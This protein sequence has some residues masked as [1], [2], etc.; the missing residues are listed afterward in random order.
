MAYQQSHTERGLCQ[1]YNIGLMKY[2]DALNL[3][4]RLQKARIRGELYDD[5]V[6]IVEHYPVLTVGKSGR[7]HD[8]LVSQEVLAE[9][10][11]SVIHTE[12]GGGVTFH[13]PGQLVVYPIFDLK[14]MEKSLYQYV[15]DLEEVVIRVLA[16]FSILGRRVEKYPGVWVGDQKICAIGIHILNGVT[17]HGFALNVNNE[18]KYFSYIHPC[19]IQDRGVTSISKVLQQELTIND[20]LPFLVWHF[21]QVFNFKKM[22]WNTISH[23][24]KYT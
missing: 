5:L 12:R 7:K 9:K 14:R 6:L 4:Q 3:Q 15:R 2:E 18:L 8:I 19:G 20:V 22:N 24:S 17:S 16:D 11:I 1:I 23:L 10:G 21:G 13:S